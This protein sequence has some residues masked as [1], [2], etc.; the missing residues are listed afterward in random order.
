METLR[1]RDKQFDGSIVPG[2]P[3]DLAHLCLAFVPLCHHGRLK[4]VC[5]SWHAALSSKILLNIRNR[6]KKAEEFLCIFRDDPSVAGGEI[7]D[8]RNKAWALL[9]LMPCDLSTYG[10]SNFCCVAVGAEVFVIG[11]S[12]FDARNYPLDKPLASS[13][14]F[15]CDIF[16]GSW[17]QLSDMTVPRGS[18]ACAVSDDFL[19]VAGGSSRHITLP[20]EGDGV[21]TVEIYDM[22]RNEWHFQEGLKTIRAGC[23]GFLYNEEF[24]VIGGYGGSR[25]IAGVLPA[26]EHYRDGEILNL[27]SGEWRYLQPMWKEGERRKLGQVAIIEKDESFGIFML[28]GSIIFRYNFSANVWIRESVLPRKVFV[29]ASSRMV[30]LDGELFVYSEEQYLD[31]YS[32]GRPSLRFQVYAPKKKSWRFVSTQPRL[33]HSPR[34]PWTAACTVRL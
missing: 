27:R 29:K 30:A 3:D 11:G 4:V 19:I 24:W 28:E 34:Y 1:T 21:S 16:C 18:F 6:W 22:K 33:Y 17:K 26:D 13:A 9:P 7:F 23:V 32:T 31:P 25:T 2:L 20:S 8:P 12:L 14:V 5:K 10:L 15:K